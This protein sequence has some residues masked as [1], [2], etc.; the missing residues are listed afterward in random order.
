MQI[1]KKSVKL[2]KHKLAKLCLE[3]FKRD[4][5]I[6]QLDK[7]VYP[8]EALT[9]HHIIPRARLRLD[10][11]DNILTVNIWDHIPLHDGV[12]AVSID[13]IIERYRFRLGEYLP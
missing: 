2:S 9:G 1:P 4:G 8:V 11:L 6:C 7:L 5:Y 12:L 3:A 13:D 10:I